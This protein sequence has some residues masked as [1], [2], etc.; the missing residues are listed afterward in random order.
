[1]VSGKGS[2]IPGGW[3]LEGPQEVIKVEKGG[4]RWADL[5]VGEKE[6]LVEGRPGEEVSVRAVGGVNIG[7]PKPG[8]A[9]MAGCRRRIAVRPRIVCR[10]AADGWNGGR[11]GE[12]L[13]LTKGALKGD[14]RAEKNKMRC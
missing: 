3:P 13:S 12:G 2:Y 1:M 9:L 5:R 6:K 10:C 11:V 14:T 7:R 4:L 8:C